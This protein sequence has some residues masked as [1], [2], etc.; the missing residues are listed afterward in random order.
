MNRTFKVTRRYHVCGDVW[1][2]HISRTYADETAARADVLGA[3]I[4]MVTNTDLFDVEFSFI[5]FSEDFRRHTG[6]F[7]FK[8][9]KPYYFSHTDKRF[10]CDCELATFNKCYSGVHCN[11]EYQNGVF[12][13]HVLAIFGGEINPV[14]TVSYDVERGLFE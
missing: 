7:D 13:P 6:D 14:V 8:V 2:N 11:I 9:E 10:I 5:G 1:D 4:E 12:F 3:L